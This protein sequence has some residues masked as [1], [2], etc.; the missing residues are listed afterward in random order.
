MFSKA[1]I[2]SSGRRR[3]IVFLFAIVTA[4]GFMQTD[5][6]FALDRSPAMDEEKCVSDMPRKLTIACKQHELILLLIK[7]QSFS[8]IESEWKRVLDLKLGD[9]Y[10]DPIAKSL[11]TISYM[12]LDAKQF[13]LAQK[14]LDESLSI[15]PFSNKSKADIFA[16]KAALFNKSGDVDS[17]IKAM[18]KSIEL[19]QKL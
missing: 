2:G 18:R 5:M 10:E 4:L 12:L 8:S 17:A 16:C 7:N 9:E 14:L 3:I 19:E 11:V 1:N 13:P 15:V 6:L